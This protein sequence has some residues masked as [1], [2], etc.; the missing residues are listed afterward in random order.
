MHVDVPML[1]ENV[2]TE[3]PGMERP[4]VCVPEIDV[5]YIINYQQ[6]LSGATQPY[7]SPSLLH[8]MPYVHV[9]R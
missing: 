1:L 2:G 8:K 6:L 3:E 7:E 5:P 9:A 4:F